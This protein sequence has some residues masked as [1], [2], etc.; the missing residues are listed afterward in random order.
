MF[1]LFFFGKVSCNFSGGRTKYSTL[2]Y[3]STLADFRFRR[4]WVGEMFFYAAFNA[5]KVSC[6]FSGGRTKYSTLTY[7]ST[8]ADFRFRRCRVR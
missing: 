2:T 1:Q 7:K 8:L 6:N 4:G 3:K 5:C